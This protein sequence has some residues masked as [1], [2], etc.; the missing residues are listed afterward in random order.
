MMHKV[1]PHK[2][3]AF[4]VKPPHIISD[5]QV[6]QDRTFIDEEKVCFLFACIPFCVVDEESDTI[7]AFQASH[8]WV[9]VL[10]SLGGN[11]NFIKQTKNLHKLKYPVPVKKMDVM[12]FDPTMFHSTA[13][14]LST[15]IRYAIS[16]T[17]L[18]KNHQFVYYFKN[19]LIDDDLIEKH[20]VDKKFY[21]GYVFSSKPDESKLKKTVAQY[22][23]FA[24]TKIELAKP[25]KKH[26]PKDAIHNTKN[27]K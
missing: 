17:V 2:G 4:Q 12:V 21:F 15:K 19:K 9:N 25:F 24:L 5:L 14:N 1:D 10:R 11:W 27:I 26:L 7:W 8:L 20:E 22:L 23:P 6:H 18:R 13:P 3:G 16:I